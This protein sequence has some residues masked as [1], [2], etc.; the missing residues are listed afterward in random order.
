[1]RCHLPVCPESALSELATPQCLH[2]LFEQQAERTPNAQAVMAHDGQFNYAELDRRSNQLAHYL[3][4][5]GVEPERRVGI[6]LPRSAE[7]IVAILAILKAGGVYVPI[8]PAYPLQRFRY[9]LEDSGVSV[10]LT[11]RAVPEGMNSQFIRVVPLGSHGSRIASMPEQVPAS[12]IV[13]RNLA[14]VIYTSGSTGKPKGVMVSHENVV[15][16]TN[17]RRGCYALPPERFLLLSSF[18]FD[19]SV[20]GIFWTLLSG[21]ELWLPP[22]GMQQ[23]V[24]RIV[25]FVRHGSITHL[26]ALPSVYNSM[27][28]HATNNELGSLRTVMVAGEPCP[29]DLVTKHFSSFI[30]SLTGQRIWSDRGDSL[31]HRI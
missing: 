24:A 22:E 12:Q 30:R 3:Q 17:A 5:L 13:G 1:V 10:L 26:L 27:L 18:S 4:S 20:G 19:S 9:L 8:D 2:R 23:N 31:V 7:M 14:Y 15:H 28:L 25:E 29:A 6:A 21:G 11:H 16:S